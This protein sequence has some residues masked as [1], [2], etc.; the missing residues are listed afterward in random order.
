MWYAAYA[1]RSRSHAEPTVPAGPRALTELPRGNSR[2]RTPSRRFAVRA[3]S[4]GRAWYGK[5]VPRPVH[6]TARRVVAG[7]G[8]RRRIVHAPRRA[9]AQL[10]GLGNGL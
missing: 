5:G 10:D 4:G 7:R 9:R 2:Q 3:A 1:V 6:M 8:G